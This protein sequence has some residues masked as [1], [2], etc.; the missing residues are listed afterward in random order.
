MNRQIRMIAAIALTIGLLAAR[1]EI[2]SLIRGRASSADQA[3]S[4][5]WGYFCVACMPV[6]VS[7]LG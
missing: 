5:G 2:A 4:D 1:G 6:V 3:P 7:L